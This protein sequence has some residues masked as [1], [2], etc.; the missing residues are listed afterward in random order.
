MR[1]PVLD[2]KM[3]PNSSVEEN[4]DKLI[5]FVHD[6]LVCFH[7]RISTSVL[8][9]SDQAHTTKEGEAVAA[10]AREGGVGRSRH[11]K[12]IGRLPSSTCRG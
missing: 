10:S 1:H 11:D 7:V 8:N 2:T 6:L 3:I 4:V 12:V 9:I 5:T